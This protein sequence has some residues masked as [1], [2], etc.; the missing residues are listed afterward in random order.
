MGSLTENRLVLLHCVTGGLWSEFHTDGCCA[1]TTRSFSVASFKCA[2]YH[3]LFCSRTTATCS[4]N[5]W[6]GHNR[7][8]P[9][10]HL[11]FR[12]SK[13]KPCPFSLLHAIPCPER[14]SRNG[15]MGPDF[16]ISLWIHEFLTI[17]WNPMTQA[18]NSMAHSFG[19]Q[20]M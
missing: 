19:H 2:L 5:L 9:I 10:H 18:N 11:Q 1:C 6:S 4:A 17:C 13:H 16:I 20:I 7:T 15:Y 8:K 14:H 12:S 3:T